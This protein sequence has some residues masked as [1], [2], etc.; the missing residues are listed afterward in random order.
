MYYS[1]LLRTKKWSSGQSS[2]KN[3]NRMDSR[4]R[5]MYKKCS[6]C[7]ALAHKKPQHDVHVSPVGPKTAAQDGYSGQ[8]TQ[9]V[10]AIQRFRKWCFFVT[11]NLLLLLSTAIDQSIVAS[12]YSVLSSKSY[13]YT[14]NSLSLF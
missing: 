14:F 12:A 5:N 1:P 13:Y 2:K 8:Q 4:V 6:A 3:N 10:L 9:F 7:F 11:H